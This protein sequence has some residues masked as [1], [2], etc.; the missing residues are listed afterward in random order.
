[1]HLYSQVQVH[2]NTKNLFFSARECP[3]LTLRTYAHIVSVVI[4]CFYAGQS[5]F[6]QVFASGP[7]FFEFQVVSFRKSW[8]I[9]KSIF[10]AFSRN[11]VLSRNGAFSRNSK[12]ASFYYKNDL[13]CILIL[14]ITFLHCVTTFQLQFWK[15]GGLNSRCA[16][17]PRACARM[18]RGVFSRTFRHFPSAD[19]TKEYFREI[20]FGL[21]IDPQGY[22]W[23]KSWKN[24]FTCF[25]GIPEFA[26]SAR[27]CPDWRYKRPRGGGERLT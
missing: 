11:L 20:S 8:K 3:Q 14:Y 9:P 15:G 16:R 24:P 18:P 7:V 21:N 19:G 1:M 6:G 2:K 23:A 17:M 5:M 12:I 4:S 13:S 26:E 25:H 10:G 27:E 22:H